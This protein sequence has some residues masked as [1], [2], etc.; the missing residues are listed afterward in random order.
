MAILSRVKISPQQRFDLEDFFAGQSAARTDSKLSIKSFIGP[1]NLVYSGFSVSGL[2]LN[3][4]TVGM[5]GASLIIPQNSVDFSYFIAPTGAADITIT[6]AQLVDGVRNYVEAQLTTIDDTPLTKAFWDPEAN[7][8]AGAEFNQIVDTVTDLKISFV[9]STGGFSGSPDR[10]PVAIIDTNGSGVIKVILDRRTI[11]GRLAIPANIN[12]SYAWGTKQEPPYSMVLNGVTGTFV[13]GETI[14]IGS[15]TA[16]VLT[17]GTTAIQFNRP[18]GIN[19]TIG[20]AVT[21]GTSGAVGTVA[22]VVESFG[23]V[24]KSLGGQKNVNDALMTE[25]K[26][27][28]GTAEW[29]SDA[30]NSNNGVTNF[31]NALLVQAVSGAKWIWSGTNLSISDSSVSPSSAD[32]LANLRIMGDP[33]VLNLSRQ[34]GQGGSATIP[35]G[36]GEVL[37]IALPASGTRVWSGV[38]SG[39]TNFQTATRTAFVR[40]DTNYWLAYRQGSLIYIRGTGE[41]RTGEDS[42]IGDNVPQSLLDNIGLA[43]EVT[44]PAYSSTIRGIANESI[45]GRVGTLT[46]AVGDE[47][48][49]RSAYLRSDLPITWS[50]T[51]VSFNSNIIFEAINTKTGVL[52]QH[53]VLTSNSPITVNA[54]ES[55]YVLIDRTQTSENVT[56][57]RSSVTPVPA[58]TQSEKDVIILFHRVDVSG[59]AYLHLPFM[60]SLIGQGQSVRLGQSGGSGGV[61]TATYKNS[62]N[63]TLPTGTS[64]SPDG[65]AVVNGDTV[66]FTNL[67]SG[68]NEIYQVSGVGTSLVWTVQASFSGFASPTAGSAIVISGGSAFAGQ[69]GIYSGTAWSFN[70]VI[71]QF[72]GSTGNY[73]EQSSLKS[74]TLA[75]NTSNAPVFSVAAVGSENM[76]VDYSVLRNGTKETGTLWMAYDGT[77]VYVSG[78]T[79]YSGVLGVTFSA[80]LNTGNLRLLASTTST[81]FAGTMKYSVKRWS[82][83]SGGPSSI[84][85]YTASVASVNNAAFCMSDSSGTALNCTNPTLVGGKTRVQ[86]S[87]TFLLAANPGL[88]VGDLDVYVNGQRFPRFVSGVTLDGFYREISNSLIEFQTDLSPA[89]LSIEIVKKV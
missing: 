56:P 28:K 42:D 51:Q 66:L 8:G 45:V 67:G 85:S 37:F 15:E 21:G 74:A 7:N 60:K 62:T 12:N 44:P 41:L 86:L 78:G 20:S 52:A 53:T 5:T 3:A 30:F 61:S 54:N 10:I 49:D 58:Q 9:V 1:N 25:I 70:N 34:D 18:S 22:S 71:R 19:Y 72:D 16:T 14:S 32:V 87:F 39:A 83:S 63:A 36:D 31:Q 55:V 57:V 88:T 27:L 77:N 89:P 2:G 6:D 68:N 73:F 29:Y 35:V 17:G 79:A 50:G 11:F 40:N 24:D 47:Q 81:G 75:D 4:A 80:D 48:E 13:Q 82:D 64:Y 23:G 76:V 33:R 84:T 43:D 38:G 46:D 26:N 69:L 59:S 65:T